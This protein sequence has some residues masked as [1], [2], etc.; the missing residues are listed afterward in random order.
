MSDIE[1]DELSFGE[2]EEVEEEEDTK[3]EGEVEHKGEDAVLEPEDQVQL[4]L[5]TVCCWVQ[6]VKLS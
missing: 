5:I 6:R 1:E 4:T 3:E 2:P